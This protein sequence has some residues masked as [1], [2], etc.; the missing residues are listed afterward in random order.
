[1]QILEEADTGDTM[2]LEKINYETGEYHEIMVY[3]KIER[4]NEIDKYHDI[5]HHKIRKKS[6]NCKISHGKKYISFM[7]SP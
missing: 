4:Y 5:K 6:R 2:K 1:M 3:N 7:S